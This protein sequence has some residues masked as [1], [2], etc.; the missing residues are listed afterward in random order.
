[1]GMVVCRVLLFGFGQREID[2]Q[3]I[4]LDKQMAMALEHISNSVLF[5]NCIY[6]ARGWVLLLWL[7][8]GEQLSF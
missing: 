6:R 3:N 8:I 2:F 5:M 1:M 4:C 7:M